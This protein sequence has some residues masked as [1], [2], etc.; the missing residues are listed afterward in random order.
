MNKY[1][2]QYGPQLLMAMV[3]F[4]CVQMGVVDPA[5]AGLAVLNVTPYPVTPEL[6]AIAVAYRNPSLI[7]DAVL[8]RVT[9][10]TKEFKYLKYPKGTFFTIPDTKV[11]RKGEP[12]QVEM[13]AEETSAI[14]ED[15]GLDDVVPNEDVQ[16][17]ASQPN[18]PNP[19]MKA[20]EFV[21]DLVLLAREVRAAGLVFDANQ[22]AAGN[23]VTLA[24][25][26]QWSVDHADSDPISDI[27][28]GLD[29]CIMRP[30]IMVIGR[31]AWTKLA[32]HKKIVGAV[33][34]AGTDAGI[35]PRQAVADLFELE[36]VLV[37][38]GFVNTAK[39]GQA[40]VP[41]RVWGKHCVLA[42]RN[43]NAD[44]QRG[45]TFGL[46]GQWGP[47]AAGT[48]SEPRVGL[49]GSQVVRVGESVKEIITANDLAYM[50][51]NAVA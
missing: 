36:E 33:Y 12:N 42:H 24:G 7:A 8:P 14:C 44:T 49:R 41:A 21:T 27:M 4:A 40:V 26:D 17:A 11:G 39:K 50:V 38:E 25:N 29:A 31:A 28:T 51:V 48:M 37:G 45:T 2:S 43:K 46:T 18:L 30:N 47:R 10:G 19:L 9:V 6:T 13:E 34:K 32:M 20:T 15:H 3:V 5:A 35:V 16:A 23:K 22:Y 1:I